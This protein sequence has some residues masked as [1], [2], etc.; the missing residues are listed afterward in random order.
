MSQRKSTPD[1]LEHMMA[2]VVEGFR[3]TTEAIHTLRQEQKE[4]AQAA[5]Q[6]MTG[7]GKSRYVSKLVEIERAK[8]SRGAQ[9][10]VA[11]T[12]GISEGR[13]SQLLNSD[14]NRKNGK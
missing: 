2:T 3:Q 1:P 13:V 7:S 14:K 5:Y 9:S 11:D 6:G 10:R 4:Q 8:E 12:L